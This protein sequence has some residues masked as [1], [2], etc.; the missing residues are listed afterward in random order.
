MKAVQ[1]QDPIPHRFLTESDAQLFQDSGYTR[2]DL[3][4]P[5][6]EK[7]GGVVRYSKRWIDA[8]F[9]LVL[10]GF[11]QDGESIPHCFEPCE[12]NL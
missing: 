10:V 4:V 11:I 7:K 12:F 8:R 2:S 6:F 9:E 1:I 5:P 3:I